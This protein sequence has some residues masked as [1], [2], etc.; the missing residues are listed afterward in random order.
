MIDRIFGRVFEEECDLERA[1]P[2]RREGR[3]HV[4]EG[5][6]EEISEPRVREATLGLRRSRRENP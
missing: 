1:T 3:Q 4:V 2:R 5:V 6:F